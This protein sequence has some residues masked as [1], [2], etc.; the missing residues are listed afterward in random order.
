M[1]SEMCIR[2]STELEYL[3]GAS[4]NIQTQIDA[5]STDLSDYLPLTGGDL[6]GDTSITTNSTLSIKPGSS[7]SIDTGATF[8]GNNQLDSDD[9]ADNSVNSGEITDGTI[10]NSDINTN[11]A[12]G[13]SKL[14]PLTNNLALVSGASG[15][16][17]VSSITSTELEYLDGAS[18]NIQTQIAVSYTHL[19]LPTK[20][21]V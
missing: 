5:L 10:L 12:I 13:L 17:S 19:T 2:D 8:V 20:R 3:D 14:A 21:I 16:G 11:A 9:L 4:S 15:V 7:L 1:G 6:T 18:S